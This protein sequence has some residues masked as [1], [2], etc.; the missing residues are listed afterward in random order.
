M[1]ETVLRVQ[2]LRKEYGKLVA[3]DG[4]DLEARAGEVMGFLGPNGAG[5]TT[6]LRII[7]GLME[8]SSGRV[9]IAGVDA[10]ADPVAAKRL[11]GFVPD[12]PFLYEK[13]T[14]NEFIR[15]VGGLYGMSMDLAQKR[16]TELLEVFDL[17]E[18]ADDRI[19]RYSHGMKQRL[20]ITSALLHRPKLFV[21]DEPMVGLDPKGAILVKELFRKVAE[22]WGGAVLMSTHAL[23]VAERIC[24]RVAI[25]DR[26]KIVANDRVDRLRA[27][28]VETAEG[29]RPLEDIF[30]EVTGGADI[31]GLTEALRS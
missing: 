9:N 19:E 28:G 10:V 23:E 16:G 14:A 20:A 15:F 12:R 17:A 25:I 24:D 21:I 3:V 27:E 22:Q 7:V 11:V 13:L 1:S 26:G 2:A 5:K 30:L 8:A 31:V 6:T 4:V 29:S 18:R